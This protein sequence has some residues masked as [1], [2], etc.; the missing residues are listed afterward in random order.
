LSTQV[1]KLGISWQKY[2]R[3]KREGLTLERLRLR[4]DRREAERRDQ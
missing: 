4:A 2:E 1:A 3:L